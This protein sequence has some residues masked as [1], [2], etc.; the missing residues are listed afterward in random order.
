VSIIIE[1]FDHDGY[2][3]NLDCHEVVRLRDFDQ[4]MKIWNWV[5][6]TVE[7]QVKAADYRLFG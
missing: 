1:E 3:G 2:E 5:I 4:A 7:L 6:T